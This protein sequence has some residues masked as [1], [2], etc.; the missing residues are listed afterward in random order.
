MGQSLL[1]DL[2]GDAYTVLTGDRLPDSEIS[3]AALKQRIVH[4]S[5]Q[6]P[7]DCMVEA[8]VAGTVLIYLAERGHNPRVQNLSDA[9][10]TVTNC[11]AAVA[12]AGGAVTPIGKVILGLV[13][14]IGPGLQALVAAEGISHRQIPPPA[15]ALDPVVVARLEHIAQVLERI[16]EHRLATQPVIPPEPAPQLTP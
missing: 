1:A 8:T 6:H 7:I 10:W 9:F 5:A 15:A 11:I 4:Y 3:Y 14:G 2:L 13:M 16:L 12:D